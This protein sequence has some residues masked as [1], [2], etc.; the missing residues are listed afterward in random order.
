[1]RISPISF[2][3]KRN[4]PNAFKKPAKQNNISFGIY[5]PEDRE[6]IK[7]TLGFTDDY[8]EEDRE[9]VMDKLAAIKGFDIK[10]GSPDHPKGLVYCDLIQD[11]ID[12][13]SI[14]GF[15]PCIET[16]DEIYLDHLEDEENFD[17]FYVDAH[18]IYELEHP[19][20]YGYSSDKRKDK[21]DDY[22]PDYE[23][24]VREWWAIMD[25]ITH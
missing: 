25:G 23:W 4:Q 8:Y 10:L 13:S 24:K 7:N 9:R 20:I 17:N 5:N 1:M 22:D 3:L 6:K 11:V 16:D 19:E 21:D 14:E 15:Y 18:N 12:N 2:N